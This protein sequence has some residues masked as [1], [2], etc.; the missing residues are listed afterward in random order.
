[1]RVICVVLVSLALLG[2]RSASAQSWA[3]QGSAGPTVGD[4]GHSVAVGVGWSPWSRVTL[5][6][7]A[8]RTHLAGETGRTAEGFWNVRGGTLYLATAEVRV[9]PL[10]RH[11]VGP[12]VLAGMATGVSRPNVNATFPNRVTND[13]G[14]MF[15][16][17]GLHVPL[18]GNVALVADG[19][20]VVGADGAEGLVVV[21]P[22]RAGVAWRF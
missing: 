12:I 1:M 6:V 16:G 14:A 9:T 15:I 20:F 4:P 13:A 21:A 17:G 11:R 22:V 5:L 8:E 7:S 18:R 19:R 3:V 2:A 10:G